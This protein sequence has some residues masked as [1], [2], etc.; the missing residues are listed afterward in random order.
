MK[1]LKLEL[2]FASRIGLLTLVALLLAGCNTV[3]GMGKDIKKAG[4]KIER[5][6]GR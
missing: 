3:Q 6:A 4:E 2:S 5:S 1:T